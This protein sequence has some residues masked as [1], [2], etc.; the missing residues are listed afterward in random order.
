MTCGYKEHEHSGFEEYE[1][2]LLSDCLCGCMEVGRFHKIYRF[3]NG[4]GASVLSAS[5]K[6]PN[7]TGYKALIIKFLGERDFEPVD[8][9]GTGGTTVVCP[10]WSA[11]ADVLNRLKAL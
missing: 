8:V 3:S 1:V 10:D 9:L 5:K 7:S 4:Y 11:V 6:D 2:D